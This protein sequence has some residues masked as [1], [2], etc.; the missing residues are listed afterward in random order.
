MYQPTQTREVEKELAYT[1]VAPGGV[2]INSPG[3]QQTQAKAHC[4]NKQRWM[5][6]TCGVAE[7]QRWVSSDFAPQPVG[8]QVSEDKA[9]LAGQAPVSRLFLAPGSLTTWAD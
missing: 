7:G 8:Y 1:E 4:S 9:S 2:R 3:E 5:V 6:S